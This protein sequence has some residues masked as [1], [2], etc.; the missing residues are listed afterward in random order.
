VSALVFELAQWLL[1][2]AAVATV[3]LA[4]VLAARRFIR[5]EAHRMA[6][7]WSAWLALAGLAIVT[8]LPEWP[9]IYV[10]ASGGTRVATRFDGGEGIWMLSE[11]LPPA[12]PASAEVEPMLEPAAAR[13][14]ADGALHWQS[15]IVLAW[16]GTAGMSCLW[17]GLGILQTWRLLWRCTRAPEWIAA[18]LAK[19]VGKRR[20]APGLLV[21]QT[22]AS[23]AA[24]G[25]IRPRIL[26][27]HT[28]EAESCAATVRAALAHEWAHIRHGD[29]WLL[30]IERLLFVLLAWHPLFWWLRREVRMDQEL[31]ADAAA[32]GEHPVE[33]AEA[34]LE[35]AKTASRP[36]LG[37]A[38]L[39]F[40]GSS[41]LW[42]S[43]HT[44]SRRVT[45]LL[46]PKRPTT[47]LAKR[48]VNLA[49]FTGLL[50]VAGGLSLVTLRPLTADDEPQTTIASE[51]QVKVYE[52]RRG[53]AV[54]SAEMLRGLFGA[55]SGATR[56]LRISADARTNSIVATGMVDDLEAIRGI[57]EKLEAGQAQTSQPLARAAKPPATAPQILLKCIMFEADESEV[58]VLLPEINSSPQ[59]SPELAVVVQADDQW[60]EGLKKLE[61]SRGTRT[62]HRPQLI[63]LNGQPAEISIESLADET[64]KA[65]SKPIGLTLKLTPE[66]L[67]KQPEGP[68]LRLAVEG[69]QTGLAQTH[70]QTSE[71]ETKTE[72][73][74]VL[75]EFRT[76][77]T[78]QLGKTAIVVD[79]NR[80]HPKAL[81]LAI[82]A[83]FV[84]AGQV[85]AGQVQAGQ[86]QA[87]QVQTGQVQAGQ[88]QAGQAPAKTRVQ[89]TRGGEAEPL[90]SIQQRLIELSQRRAQQ[91][92]ADAKHRQELLHLRYEIDKLL[93]DNQQRQASQGQ[94]QLSRGSAY[95]AN[96]QAAN[97]AVA[98]EY[99]LA[100]RNLEQQAEQAAANAK[101][102]E[103][104]ER[105]TRIRLMELD[106]SD[107]ELNLEAARV[108]LA[109]LEEARRKSPADVSSS[110]LALAKLAVRRAELQVEKINVQLEGLR[111]EAAAKESVDTTRPSAAPRH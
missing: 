111:R 22:L 106:R 41:P 31:L 79:R 90:E 68:V 108:E 24:V 52:L 54:A 96:P 59:P 74:V 69:K 71:G 18:E 102:A 16:V 50:A 17:I 65:R 70:E 95:A 66:V 60:Q 7:A 27:P 94:N 40:W 5:S 63:T 32:A 42:E 110:Q 98:Q 64:G 39:S 83:Q 15:I 34:L 86:V 14:Q 37:L 29:L 77:V 46:D 45:M 47:G 19:L 55:G 12:E 25:A 81:V 28:V 9:R 91:L 100:R 51:Y 61:L 73:R 1:D 11:T 75:R 23:A 82:E 3:L 58:A 93:G 49:L 62:L 6:L 10:L 89:E 2:F 56:A 57:L 35:W 38:A 101:T 92:E 97:S 87:G 53:D 84:Q 33:Y 48:A 107:A 80:R 109:K 44:L 26:L 76:Q 8:G 21:S 103:S 36:P 4:A 43:P 30:A 88:V 20:R 78:P 85:Q 99:E 105:Q 104:V 13:F 72:E 67:P